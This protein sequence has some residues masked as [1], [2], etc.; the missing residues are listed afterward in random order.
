MG[1]LRKSAIISGGVGLAAVL[2]YLASGGVPTLGS[3]VRVVDA[4]YLAD[5][6]SFHL[7]LRG[8]DG[9][10]FA[11]GAVGSLNKPPNQ[12][13]VYTQRWWPHVPLPFY[14]SRGSMTER[15][16]LESLNAWLSQDNLSTEE[17][18]M[19]QSTASLLRSR[20]N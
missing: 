8:S 15:E 4:S 19:M 3:P 10:E 17:R 11:L 12:F 2:V 18:H 7:V 14:V 1:A 6:G 9:K 16:L 20:A 5:G 13:S